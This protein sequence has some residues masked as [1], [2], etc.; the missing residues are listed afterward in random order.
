M[1]MR[2]HSFTPGTS[3]L[4]FFAFLTQVAWV[5]LQGKLA[6]GSKHRTVKSVVL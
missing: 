5:L 3:D 6:K 1:F 2:S 4:F